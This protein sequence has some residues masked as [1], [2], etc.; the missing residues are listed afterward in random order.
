MN[1]NSTQLLEWIELGE[2]S[3]VEFKM[4]SFTKKG[5]RTPR[6]DSIANEL[7]AFGNSSGGTL[8]FNISDS[9]DVQKMSRK[10]MD[11]LEIFI[12]E[13]SSDSIRPPFRFFTKRIALPNGFSVITIKIEQST[14]VHKSSGGYLIRSGSSK[15]E[16]S[17]EALHRLFRQR[18][19]F[20]MLGPDEVI[21]ADT[22]PNTL[23][24]GLIDRFLSS[25]VIEH[26]NI[27]LEKLG[28]IRDDEFGVARAT[29]AGVLLASTDPNKYIH[30]AAI[31]AVRYQGTV[32]GTANQID[33]ALITG[34]L[35]Q[36]I[37]DAVNFT[38]RNTRVAARKNPGRVEIPQFSPRTVFEA[39][40]NAVVHRDYSIENAKIRLI[41]FDDRLELYSPGA[42]PNTLSIDAMPARQATRNEVVAA[43]LGKLVIGDIHGSGDRQYFLEQ[44]GEGVPIIYEETRELTGRIPVYELLDDVELLLLI[45]SARP[46]VEGLEGHITVSTGGRPL[47]GVKVVALYPNKTWMEQQTDALGQVSFSFYARLPIT[48]F[49]AESGYTAHVERNWNP[50]EPLSIQLDSLPTGG[51][52]VFTERTGHLPRLSGR[53]NPILDSHDRMYLYAKNIAID[54]EKQQP[55]HFKLN[56]SVRLTDV[57]GIELSVRFIDFIG[58]TSLLE[59]QYLGKSMT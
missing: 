56:Q 17:P 24:A 51:S 6:R 4:A 11:A 14:Q 30:G 16:L 57:H 22:G 20:G 19:R 13:I 5:V 1:L 39:I 54:C 25:R 2:D 43:L 41:I 37:R 59:Y 35:D 52:C 48:V 9:G 18:G 10:E 15:R 50:P 42:L 29:V 47:A 32:L 28:M 3:T 40:V 53:L 33:A 7:A 21:V 27:Q 31:N 58:N 26:S 36:Q 12:N 8:V 34:P 45:P 38:K 49:C 46:P 55:V 23:D 44:R